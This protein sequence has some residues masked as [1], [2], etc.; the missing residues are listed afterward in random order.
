[1]ICKQQ[2]AHAS[3]NSGIEVPINNLS[4]RPITVS[5]KMDKEFPMTLQVA[6]VGT[7]GI[8]LASDTKW[9]ETRQVRHTYNRT[10]IEI[11]Y[12]RRIAVSYAR[13]MDSSA[14]AA[15]DIANKITDEQWDSPQ[16]RIEEI[17]EEAMQS[18]PYNIRDL[19][20]LIVS[21]RMK[22]F[23]LE[24]TQDLS[25][26]AFEARPSCWESTDK[27][28]AGDET[29]AALFWGERYYER[30]P[31]RTLVPLAA[32]LINAGNKLSPDRIEGLE[33]VLCEPAGIRRLSED[34][35]RAL[36]S[37]ANGLDEHLRS[38]FINYSEQF[39]YA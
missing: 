24:M 3:Q 26:G 31:I 23:R 27:A 28:P 7:D 15:K 10:K 19:N 13:N 4:D 18:L 30:R 37:M 16:L 20:C 38:A 2:V 8:V 5:P 25:K 17:A 21:P 9:S 32:Y 6:L 36:Q 39:T 12:E 1:M 29:N 11:N 14:R 34:S 35:I 22:L 33:I